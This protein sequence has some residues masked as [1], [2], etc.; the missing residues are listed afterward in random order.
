MKG[1]RGG[2]GG[3]NDARQ[4]QRDAKTESQFYEDMSAA[5]E[6]V[7]KE[8]DDCSAAVRFPCHLA[9]WDLGHCDPKKCSGRKL[10][11]FGFIKEL[12]LQQ[13][14]GGIVLSPMGK[15]CVSPSDKDIIIQHG[16][17]VIDCSW[18]RIDDTPFSKMKSRYPRLLP[19]LVA[20]NPINY[21]RPWKLSCAEAFAAALYIVGLKELG[22]ILL[23]KFKWGEGFYS[24]NQELLDRYANC[25]TS[26][27][28]VT[29]Q[30]S[31]LEMLSE[32]DAAE[33]LRDPTEIGSDEEYFNP[34]RTV[35]SF[36]NRND[37]DDSEELD[38]TEDEETVDTRPS[39]SKLSSNDSE[40][41]VE[42]HPPATELSSTDDEETTNTRPDDDPCD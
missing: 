32:Q 3:K 36:H 17:A 37:D 2:R 4:R 26:A 24:M 31:Y 14:F 12:R 25:Q 8:E 9:M 21:G 28:V 29:A 42:K 1:H 13:H 39:L 38:S 34:N 10:V 23:K 30:Q 7:N 20:T 15:V 19:Y 33:R 6:T 22:L 11:R 41:T 18:A 16:L 27:E 5:L 40:V 35:T